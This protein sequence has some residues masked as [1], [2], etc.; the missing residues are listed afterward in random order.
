MAAVITVLALFSVIALSNASA[1]TKVTTSTYLLY[2]G[3]DVGVAATTNPNTG[4]GE[5][6]LTTDFIH[7]RNITPPLKIPKSVAKGQC[8]YVWSDASFTSPTVG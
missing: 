8:L 7:W 6:F 4:C 3:H 1:S 5:V 2:V